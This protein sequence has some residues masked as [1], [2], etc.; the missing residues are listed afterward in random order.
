MAYTTIPAASGGAGSITVT[1]G[2]GLS[3]DGSG[4]SPLAGI[5]ASA[6]VP[7]TMSAAS[8]SKE[9][10]LPA[11]VP[12]WAFTQ[13]TWLVNTAAPAGINAWTF[14]KCG[15]V[16]PVTVYDAAMA[17][18]NLEGG[19]CATA[20]IANFGV[21]TIFL[22]AKTGKFVISFYG[23]LAAPVVARSTRFGIIDVSHTTVPAEVATV[24]A[25]SATKYLLREIDGGGVNLGTLSGAGVTA[26]G[27]MHWFTL[28]GDAT[29]LSMYVDTTLGATD[30]MTHVTDLAVVPFI[31]NTI[32][33]D[34]QV[35]GY[36][37][38]YVLPT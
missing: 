14:H 16:L 12:T 30:V 2:T 32:A 17:D 1:A 38:G 34:V 25:T 31:T 28:T 22:K 3:G 29:T 11:G 8:F 7:G 18:A 19:G 5:P 33:Q 35:A 4:G 23:K 37:V 6:S 20:T 13:Y 15:G 26:D 21:Q 9:A 36:F 10:L 27:N 24:F